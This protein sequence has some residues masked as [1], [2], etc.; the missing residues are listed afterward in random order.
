MLAW[1]PL[2]VLW[3]GIGESSKIIVIVIAAYFPI[4]LNTM[5]GIKRTDKKLIEVGNMYN[6]S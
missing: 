4:L 3:F 1:I 6:L 2:I 5:N